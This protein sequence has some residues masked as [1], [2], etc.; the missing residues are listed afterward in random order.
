MPN[1]P[2]RGLTSGCRARI[3]RGPSHGEG[4]DLD[5]VFGGRA[6]ERR[7]T[8][9]D[10][11]LLWARCREGD[12]AA[13]CALIERFAPLATRIARG[14]NVPVGAVAGPDDLESAA[15][16][17]LIDAVDRFDP[18]RGVPFEGYASL[19]I[20]GAVLDEVRRVDELGRADR[21]RQR[22]AAA[23]GEAG[24]Y[25]GTVSLDDLIERGYHG[26]AEQDEL[27]ERYEAEDLRMRVRSA[28]TCLPPRQREV[29]ERYYG[30]SLT[31]REAGLR[32]GISEARACQL[33]GRAIQ[34]LRRQLSVIL[35][36]SVPAPRV[37][38]AA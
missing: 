33:H 30:Q 17:G 15:L 16:I 21:R 22:A 4:R 2:E 36:I 9:A 8:L 5:Q 11:A 14:M 38:V 31:L 24:S 13:R 19:R 23:Q 25:H 32:M 29:L 10:S 1:G 27:A 20:R 35:P 18:E 3:V 6:A 7:G 28:M 12:V 37:P 26:G 34:N